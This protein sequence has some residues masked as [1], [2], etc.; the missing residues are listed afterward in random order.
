MVTIT[1][2]DHRCDLWAPHFNEIEKTI[3][4]AS[5]SLDEIIHVTGTPAKLVE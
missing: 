4:V 2:D 5:V 1:H 3:I